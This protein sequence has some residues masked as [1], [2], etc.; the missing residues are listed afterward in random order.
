MGDYRMCY[1]QYKKY[2]CLSVSIRG[3]TLFDI[4][5]PK[6]TEDVSLSLSAWMCGGFK[7]GR[8][9]SAHEFQTLLL[10]TGLFFLFLLLFNRGC[11]F[12]CRRGLL[13]IRCQCS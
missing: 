3:Y 10:G 11:F 13:F 2:P 9:G 4:D 7:K 8:D 6:P 12:C 1:N 5:I